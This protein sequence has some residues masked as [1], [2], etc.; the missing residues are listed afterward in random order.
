MPTRRRALAL[1]GLGLAASAQGAPAPLPAYNHHWC[2]GDNW[3]PHWGNNSDWNNCHDW[4]DHGPAPMGY[5]GPPPWAPPPPGPPPW[6]PWASVS[7]NA[8]AN[9]WGFWNGGMWVPL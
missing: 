6:A 8:D 7:W 4:D 2:P 3:D 9:G 1:S 5:G